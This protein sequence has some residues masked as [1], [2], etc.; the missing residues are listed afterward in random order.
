MDRK[1]NI[2]RLKILV[3][4]LMCFCACSSKQK[5][6]IDVGKKVLNKV[7]I[8]SLEMAQINKTNDKKIVFNYLISYQYSF[9]EDV[10]EPNFIII[11]D[12]VNFFFCSGGTACDYKYTLKLNI[13][14][15]EINEVCDPETMQKHKVLFCVFCKISGLKVGQYFVKTVEGIQKIK[16]K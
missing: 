8:H 15:F 16:I 1:S 14:T 3:V 5:N 10:K 7:D 2:I 6:T 11:G 9:R 13:D 12:T 4:I